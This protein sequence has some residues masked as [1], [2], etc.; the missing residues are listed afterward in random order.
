MATKPKVI[1]YQAQANVAPVANPGKTLSV[2]DW[3]QSLKPAAALQ[4]FNTWT[5][6]QPV[7]TYTNNVQAKTAY[8]KYK[9][10][11]VKQTNTYNLYNKLSA[12]PNS[13][14]YKTLTNAYKQYT[15]NQTKLT[16]DYNAYINQTKNNPI[17]GA[18]IPNTANVLLPQTAADKLVYDTSMGAA[19]PYGA[20]DLTPLQKQGYTTTQAALLSTGTLPS[21]TN[22]GL[23]ANGNPE[24][25]A[26]TGAALTNAQAQQGLGS[27]WYKRYLANVD[28]TIVQ[29]ADIT[30]NLANARIYDPTANSQAQ[31]AA[32]RSNDPTNI[33]KYYVQPID[34]EAANIQRRTSPLVAQAPTL[35]AA[36]AQFGVQQ[37]ASG[38]SSLGR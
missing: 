36:A 16:S 31:D 23:D 5:S 4:D 13:R 33:S 28:P 37:V 17:T 2:N 18:S 1:N 27:D 38:S 7:G 10:T 21:G 14:D 12:N 15:T 6:N 22:L 9:D 24:K 29:K 26:W 20:A 8:N 32:F 19:G 11:L 25:Y 3:V 35:A 34:T 30:Q